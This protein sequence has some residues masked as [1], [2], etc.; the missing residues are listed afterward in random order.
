MGATSSLCGKLKSYID[1]VKQDT[2][3]QKTDKPFVQMEKMITLWQ[4][5]TVFVTAKCLLYKH[6]KIIRFILK[7]LDEK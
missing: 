1:E 3:Q 6:K 4:G 5:E 7:I 2:G